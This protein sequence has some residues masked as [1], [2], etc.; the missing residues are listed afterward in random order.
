MAAI[1][2]TEAKA[3]FQRWE[4]VKEFELAELRRTPMDMKLRQLST[5]MASRD[6]FGVDPQRE[7]GVR[8]VRVR[9]ACLRKGLRG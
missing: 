8:L 3:Y 1:T 9:W 7:D 4:S 2:P 6:L 5:L